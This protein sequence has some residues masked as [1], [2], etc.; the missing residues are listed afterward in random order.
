MKTF[1]WKLWRFA[2]A[3]HLNWGWGSTV[4][5]GSGRWRKVFGRL[6]FLVE[7]SNYQ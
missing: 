2:W 1:T 7:R 6:H 4:I 3:T 5:D